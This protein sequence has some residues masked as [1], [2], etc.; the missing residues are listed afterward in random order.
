MKP[1]S[2]NP[3]LY[4][5]PKCDCPLDPTAGEWED[6]GCGVTCACG[7]FVAMPDPP[8]PPVY[9]RIAKLISSDLNLLHCKA[10]LNHHK[11]NGAISDLEWDDLWIL[12]CKGH[13]RKEVEAALSK[14]TEDWR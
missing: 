4:G 8:Q 11:K 3:N 9:D 5:C 7:I 12:A 2:L 6:T 14:N 1:S 13:Q 10:L